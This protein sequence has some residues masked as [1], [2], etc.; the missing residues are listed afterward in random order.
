MLEINQ[1]V[2]G[3]LILLYHVLPQMIF[4]FLCKALH[5]HTPC[6][7][8][9]SCI[10]L[11]LGRSMLGHLKTTTGDIHSAGPNALGISF[12]PNLG[13]NVL[14]YH[15]HMEIFYN[16]LKKLDIL[17]SI[18]IKNILVSSMCANMDKSMSWRVP[19][20][21]QGRIVSFGLLNRLQGVWK[22]QIDS[23]GDSGLFPGLL[24]DSRS[25][26]CSNAPQIPS[27][28]KIISEGE[29]ALWFLLHSERCGRRGCS[30]V[31]GGGG[32]WGVSLCSEAI[33]TF[34]MCSEIAIWV[35]VHILLKRLK[36]CFKCRS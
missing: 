8:V 30:G 4:F 25:S 32:G 34:H 5:T 6:L 27:P 11:V 18:Y 29:K 28:G 12:Q 26:C 23:L 14:W 13:G 21:V 3:Y 31:E 9:L 19:C 17:F 20:H 10:W 33:A 35:L 7:K 36:S 2:K 1:K 16:I 24:A 22:G 15:V